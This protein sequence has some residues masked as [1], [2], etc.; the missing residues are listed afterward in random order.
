VEA[1]RS[2]LT[3]KIADVCALHSLHRVLRVASARSRKVW[4]PVIAVSVSKD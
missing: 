3:R 2:S 4:Q 1:L